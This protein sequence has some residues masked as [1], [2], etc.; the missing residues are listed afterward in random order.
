[1]TPTL[2]VVEPGGQG[3]VHQH[4]ASLAAAVAGRGVAVV[5]HSAADAEEPPDRAGGVVRRTC[6]WRFGGLRPAP[7]RKA[8]LAGGWV[9]I[10]VPACLARVRPGDVVH[11]EGWFRPVLLLPLVLGARLRRARVVLVPHNT[12]SRR[13]RAGEERLFRWMSRR[14]DA[15]L[16]FSDRDR[17]RIESWA[18]TTTVGVPMMFGPLPVDLD[19]VARWR[20]RWDVADDQ[21]VV[22]LAG[23]VRA[24]KGPDLLVRAA[25]HWE[26]RLVPAVVGQDLGALGA[27]RRLAAEL[28]VA[29]RVAEGYQPIEQF[30]AALYAAD[31]VVCPYRVSS[32]SGVLA[33]AAA[34]GLR[35]VATDV[36]GLPEL[37]T[38]VVPPNDPVA[39][40][41][42]VERVL[43]HDRQPPRPLADVGPYLD[44]YGFDPITARR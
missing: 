42:G 41:E 22:L 10:G 20:E 33:M 3:G 24:D 8:A 25:A 17:R 29:L 13:G 2:H 5:L 26:G 35:T 19:L 27:A 11:V 4:A 7:L 1:M 38:V 9:A 21:R 23:Q 34:L 40:A 31:V 15:V 32:Q 14:A 36:G 37:A 18:A 12:F 39:L 6:L 43:E 44:V 28:D 16:A 30:V